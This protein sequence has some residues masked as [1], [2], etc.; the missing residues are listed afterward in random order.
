MKEK[1]YKKYLC[2]FEDHATTQMCQ[3]CVSIGNLEK[4]QDQNGNIIR[5]H[6]W[7][8]SYVGCLRNAGYK[9]I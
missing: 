3:E 9:V 4:Y 7:D 2:E 1:S 8:Q 5:Q 6:D